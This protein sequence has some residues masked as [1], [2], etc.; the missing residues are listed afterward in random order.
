MPENRG[1]PERHDSVTGAGKLS[2][3][4]IFKDTMA[5]SAYIVSHKLPEGPLPDPCTKPV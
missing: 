4:V 2:E 1:P 3:S 5:Y